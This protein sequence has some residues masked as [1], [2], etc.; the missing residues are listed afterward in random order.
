MKRLSILC[1]SLALIASASSQASAQT[2]SPTSSHGLLRSALAD[3]ARG[4]NNNK[5][6]SLQAVEGKDLT[7]QD[8]QVPPI[9]KEEKVTTETYTQRRIKELER[10]LYERVKKEKT[11]GKGPDKELD[12]L[13]KPR[14]GM[15]KDEFEQAVNDKLER[16]AYQRRIDR[17]VEEAIESDAVLSQ[18]G[19]D[20]F[21][22]GDQTDANLFADTAPSNYQLGPGDSLKIIVW[23][24]M[25]DE[26]VY[27][28]QVNPEG[29]IYIPIIGILGVSGKTV[30]EFEKI[31][32]G[33]L[34]GKFTH[35]KGQVTL[36]KVRTIQIFVAGEVEK[37]GAMMV[38]GLTT[39]F[40]ALYHAGGPT[41]RGSMRNIRV[42]EAG[43]RSKEIDLYKYFLSGDRKQD[44][45]I[46]NGDTIF[47]PTTEKHIKITGMVARPAIYE[48]K[49][50]STL[51]EVMGM[52]GNLLPE[53]FAGR[54]KVTR[55]T[56]KDRRK[57]FDVDPN[58]RNEMITFM[59]KPGDEI[60]VERSSGSVENAVR[61]EGP[62]YQPGEYA[63]NDGLTVS[64]LIKLSGG[65]VA[66]TA[67]YSFGQVLRKISGD[68]NEILSFNLN[69]AL[70]GDPNNDI[71]L[72]PLDT[73]RLFRERE[74]TNEDLTVSV[75]G[76]VR[77]VGQ[78]DYHDGM[79]L[80]DLILEANGIMQEAS[81]DVE[82]ARV[83]EG[84]NSIILQ[85]NVKNALADYNS[86]DNVTLQPRD[87]INVIGSG[88]QLLVPET[89][90][91]SGQVMKPGRYALTHRGE[92]LSSLIKR[93]GG[94]TSRAFANGTVFMRDVN[95]ITTP[96]QL[97][98]T[99]SVQKELFRLANLDIRADLLKAGAKI[100]SAGDLTKESQGEGVLKQFQEN[101]NETADLAI[102]G[103]KDAFEVAHDNQD[104]KVK[105]R[106]P[107]QMEKIVAGT[108]DL[109]EDIPL[110]DGDEIT[111]PVI[112]Q[113]V[114]VLGS[115]M[116][117]TSIMFKSRARA[118]YYVDRAGGYSN[119]SDHRRTVVIRPNGEVFRLS[120]LKRIDRGDIILVPP[121]AKIIR[122]ETL[123]DMSSIASVLGNLAVT[124]KVIRDN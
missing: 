78:Y 19:K 121:K 41:E 20:F 15:T 91:L 1:V 96:D 84:G 24:E 112:P 53:A 124:Y 70:E 35:F 88:D 52:A 94:L 42:I 92:T 89:V 4:G 83:S 109:E 93:A 9:Q 60:R 65:V 31:V 63:V 103:R 5:Y 59:V 36:S 25:G 86:P 114:S 87:K 39:A 6:V 122:N 85:C 72:K 73:V 55:W 119:H 45:P 37:P 113:T 3:A 13:F 79:K 30:G 49:N 50:E 76:M 8:Q 81:G 123:K 104:T 95:N 46:K 51:D 57:S 77:C 47:V 99:V 64:A 21:V 44:I 118:S 107:I 102:G 90:L 105:T 116:N 48:L 27:D 100:D 66:E 40:S 61:I 82:I 110:M 34:A 18:F 80:S 11:V 7:I 62:V 101:T 69:K 108:A 2:S 111:I 29:Q 54:I 23:S 14:I 68:K 106:I 67:N 115:V 10:A 17:E 58:A 26:T 120:K 32:L 28:V 71:V 12:N 56:G 117:P 16:E 75:G 97:T 98:T 74:I 38:S 22:K 43:G 33:K